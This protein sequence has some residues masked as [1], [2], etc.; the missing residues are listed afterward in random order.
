MADVFPKLEGRVGVYLIV[1]PTGGRYVGSS[2]RLD[3]RFNRYKNLSC[4][5][6]SAI[7]ASLSKYGY[8]AHKFTILMY[9]EEVDLL[10]WERC[11]GDIYLASANFKQGLNLVLPGYTDV[12]QVRSAE[13]NKRVSV[14][15]KQRFS[16]PAERDRIGMLS[17]K[18]YSDPDLRKRHSETLKKVYQNPELRKKR[19]DLQKEYFKSAEA[20]ENV[21]KKVAEYYANN[22]DKI[23][24]N[25]SGLRKYYSENPT[26]RRDRANARFICNP[27]AGKEH[28]EKMKAY[29]KNNPEARVKISERTTLWLT[30]NHPRARKIIDTETGEIFKSVIQVA[31]RI[32][33]SEQTV[34]NWVNGISPNPTSYKHL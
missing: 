33:K 9:C 3:K 11:F 13:F 2:K 19:S 34:R 15:Q 24:A 21:S 29:F 23:E 14:Q 20:R 28:S 6:Q 30:N 16:D 25:Q 5:R 10:F 1:S 18:A 22:P 27:N 8:M 31:E 26:V 12:P 32:G 17:R 7:Y 4:S